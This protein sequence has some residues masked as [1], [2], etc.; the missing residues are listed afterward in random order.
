MPT[1]AV[2]AAM[3]AAVAIGSFTEE[4]VA[5]EARRAAGEKI[6]PVIPIGSL[7]RYERALPD[8]SRYDDLLCEKDEEVGP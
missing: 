1:A 7:A 8:L 5:L 4:L 6:A 2:A 3:R